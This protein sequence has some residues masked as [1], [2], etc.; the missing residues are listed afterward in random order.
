MSS[1]P[2]KELDLNVRICQRQRADSMDREKFQ[3]KAVKPTKQKK[4]TSAEFLMVEEHTEAPEGAGNPGFNMSHPELSAYQTP[5]E[6]VIGYDMLDHTLAAHQQK[7]RLPVSAGPKDIKGISIPKILY[8]ISH[9]VISSGCR[10]A[11]RVKTAQ[12]V[13]KEPSLLG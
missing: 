6:K 11:F 7:S 3:Q 13:L 9:G 1:C 8:C 4:S 10:W 5:K 2:S 12:C